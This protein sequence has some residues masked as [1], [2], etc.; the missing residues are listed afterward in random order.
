MNSNSLKIA[1]HCYNICA[2]TP[3]G[4]IVVDF[5]NQIL[6]INKQA[7]NLLKLNAAV[8]T[9]EDLP[10]FLN[11]LKEK[12]IAANCNNIKNEI[13]IAVNNKMMYLEL[14][15]NIVEDSGKKIKIITV[16]D[17]ASDLEKLE[18]VK[19]MQDDNLQ[20]KNL[21][22]IGTMISG[23]A[24]E[25]NNPIAGI[26]MSSQ[27]AESSLKALMESFKCNEHLSESCFNEFI[28]AATYCLS[29]LEHVKL[30]TARA[31]K[32]VGGLLNYSKKE[33]LEL[34]LCNLREIIDDTIKITQYQPLYYKATIL[35]SCPENI[36]LNCDKLKIQQVF[37][38][39]IKNALESLEENGLIA[40]NCKPEEKYVRI[41]ISDN[42][43]G[44][45][46]SNFDQL[47]TP[48]FT[49]K[50]PKG[51][52]GLGLSISHRIVER[53]RGKIAVNSVVDKGSEFVITLPYNLE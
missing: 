25:L 10:E 52:T 16:I 28:E 45:P 42:G 47:F 31:A 1:N 41:S 50:G 3:V 4:F 5:Q 34:Q 24:H 30:N 51:G 2:V 22:A 27:L 43:C 18:V 7:I 19:T 40:I 15:I 14:F 39:I 8:D 12:I 49:T 20:F 33:K 36:Q 21:A 48:F 26:S 17:K 38:N 46:P 6:Y 35:I 53:H 32:L 29:E 37:F 11:S 9:V 13:F 44:I 23:I